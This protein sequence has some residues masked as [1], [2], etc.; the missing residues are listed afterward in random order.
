MTT[1]DFVNTV[2]LDESSTNDFVKLP[3]IFSMAADLKESSGP[4]RS[5]TNNTV[6]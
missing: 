2:R 5:Q 1:I 4:I 3:R 6:G